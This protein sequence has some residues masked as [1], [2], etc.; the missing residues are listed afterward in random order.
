M[1]LDNQISISM[2]DY[3]NRIKKLSLD[4]TKYYKNRFDESYRR[5][6]DETA[7][8]TQAA[9]E[10]IPVVRE[11]MKTAANHT[12]RAYNQIEN[13][14]GSVSRFYRF[15]RYSMAAASFGILLFGAGYALRPVADI[16]KEHR[17]RVKE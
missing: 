12:S 4:N 1:H 15:T 13:I 6:T 5:V 11:G 7:K 8:A 16:Y 10:K 17:R 9:K 3:W 2:N 14:G